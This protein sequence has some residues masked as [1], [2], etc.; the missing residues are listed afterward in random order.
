MSKRL[1]QISVLTG[2]AQCAAF[3]KLW[4][5][6]HIFGVGAELDGYNLALVYP[7][8]IAGVITGIIQTGIFTIRSRLSVASG[9]NVANAF[10]RSLFAITFG[11]GI[12]FAALYFIGV[13]VFFGDFMPAIPA[14]TREAFFVALPYAVALIPIT[15]VFDYCSF[16]LALRNHFV[17]AAAAPILNGIIGAAF[18]ALWSERGLLVLASGTLIGMAVQAGICV[19]ALKRCSFQFFGK[20]PKFSDQY[21][22]MREILFLGS[23]LLPGL[24]VSNLIVSLPQIWAVSFGEGAVSAYGYAY[25]L[26]SSLLQL[27]IMASSTIILAR[28]SQLAAERS[29][30][31]IGLLFRKGVLVSAAIGLA[32]VLGVMLLGK[33]LLLAMFSGR[34]EEDAASRVSTLWFWLSIGLGFSLLG[35]LCA[36]YFQA[37]GRPGVMTAMAVIG[38]VVL[39]VIFSIL[40]TPLMENAIA[41]AVS[42]AAV[43][44]AAFGLLAMVK[45]TKA[46]RP[47][48][49][50]GNN[51]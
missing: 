45:D 29:Y 2:L 47:P 10:E 30:N 15:V 39:F 23:W 34:F 11:V 40:K 49:S 1:I 26:H 43:C 19:W 5:T 13:L 44:S 22:Y 8:F 33:P 7:V 36:K 3:I 48:Q 21:G 14:V 46:T 41:A 4:F 16:L 31:Q 18:L 12:G 51:K 20:W 37:R 35:N 17:V 42:A 6:S 9:E 24:F 27:L 32:V 25:K 38:F 28:F 50:T